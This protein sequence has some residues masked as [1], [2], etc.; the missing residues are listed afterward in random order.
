MLIIFLLDLFL[1]LMD[2]KAD[3]LLNEFRRFLYAF[4]SKIIVQITNNSNNNN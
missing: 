3:C 2:A 4:I 1:D